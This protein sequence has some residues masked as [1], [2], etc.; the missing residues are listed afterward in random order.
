MV[1]DCKIIPNKLREKYHKTGGGLFLEKRLTYHCF[2]CKTFFLYYEDK[3]PKKCSLCK[4]NLKRGLFPYY[5]NEDSFKN[6]NITRCCECGCFTNRETLGVYVCENC[7]SYEDD[8]P[9]KRE[10]LDCFIDFNPELIICRGCKERSLPSCSNFKDC[11][12]HYVFFDEQ[13]TLTVEFE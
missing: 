6:K 2:D 7:Y 5:I 13:E 9:S 11:I 12:E 1:S 3:A 8:V 4:G 10:F